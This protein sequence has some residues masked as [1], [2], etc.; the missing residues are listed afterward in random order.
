MGRSNLVFVSDGDLIKSHGE[1]HPRHTLHGVS[2]GIQEH[3][4]SARRVCFKKAIS[5]KNWRD[6]R[7]RG[8]YMF[9]IPEAIQLAKKDPV[10]A[11][12]L[13]IFAGPTGNYIP[14]RSTFP[15]NGW[16]LLT[17]DDLP[18]KAYFYAALHLTSFPTTAE[19][20]NKLIRQMLE[21][22]YLHR[23]GLQHTE[24]GKKEWQILID[25]IACFGDLADSILSKWKIPGKEIKSSNANSTPVR[26]IETKKGTENRQILPHTNGRQTRITTVRKSN[27]P[28][29]HHA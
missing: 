16:D 12:A 1:P 9:E 18:G 19:N 4:P 27:C 28:A 7:D 26:I 13:E 6:A 5:P 20:Q 24:E 17:V 10:V 14:P 29:E 8:I 25:N 23:F 21:Q 22:A 11:K 3:F 2:S 15:V